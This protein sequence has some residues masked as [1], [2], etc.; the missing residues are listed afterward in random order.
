MCV[1]GDDSPLR[2][3]GEGCIGRAGCAIMPV[4]RFRGWM[5]AA[6]LA[7]VSGCGPDLVTGYKPRPLGDSPAARRAYYAGKYTPAARAADAE[8]S[9]K[10]K[11]GVTPGGMAGP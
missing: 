2:P 3:S 10:N 7:V 4:M 1:G 9:D 6:L 5:L 11:P 8:K